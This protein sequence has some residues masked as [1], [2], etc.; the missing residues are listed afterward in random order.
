M[1]A[2][3]SE[4]GQHISIQKRSYFSQL[5]LI[6][7][8]IVVAFGCY[9]PSLT[10]G[11]MGDDYFAY[12][13]FFKA[14]HTNPLTLLQNFTGSWMSSELRELH[15]R[16]FMVI[17]HLFDC[18]A[19]HLNPFGY[20]LTNLIIH[21][22]CTALVFLITR[23]IFKSLHNS[24]NLLPPFIAALLFAVHPLHAEAVS[25]IAGRVDSF[26]TML[27]LS[28]FFL[29]L[30]FQ[31]TGSTYL[32]MISYACAL[33]AMMSKEIGAALPAVLTLYILC[34]NLAAQPILKTARKALKETSIYWILLFFYITVRT[35]ALKTLLGGYAGLTGILTENSWMHRIQDLK[36][37]EKIFLPI[38]WE[39]MQQ[40]SFYLVVLS[41]LSCLIVS[42]LLIRLWYCK[43]GLQ[44]ARVFCFATAWIA[45][46]FAIVCRVWVETEGLAGGR[47][48]YLLSVPYCILVALLLLPIGEQAKQH[49]ILNIVATSIMTLYCSVFFLITFEQNQFWTDAAD[50]SK[51]FRNAIISQIPKKGPF[52]VLNVPVTHEHMGLY[53]TFEVLRGLFSWPFCNPDLTDRVNSLQPYFYNS[54]LINKSALNM[55]LTDSTT[56]I[57]CWN[58]N[59]KMAS[60]YTSF[61]S[62]SPNYID[63]HL[64][65]IPHVERALVY[66]IKPLQPIKKQNIDC[67]E[68]SIACKPK[69]RKKPHVLALSW[70]DNTCAPQGLDKQVN[71]WQFADID[72]S[73]KQWVLDKDE[74]LATCLATLLHAE[75]DV[76]TYRFHLSEITSWNLFGKLDSL[77][78]MLTDPSA[79]YNIKS[80]KLLN[81]SNEIPRLSLQNSLWAR[82]QNGTYSAKSR[83]KY[84]FDYD[85]SKIKGAVKVIVEISPPDFYW[86]YFTTSY[87]Q[88]KLADKKL[89]TLMLN[90]LHGTFVIDPSIF[91][92]QADYQIHIAALDS[93][94]K[95]LDYV[96]DPLTI[97]IK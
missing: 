68:I 29:F 82:N 48:F 90:Q 37:Y 56:K 11:F 66:H 95:I 51:V 24:T 42:V 33:G 5:F 89:K 41:L 34:E 74:H 43:P 78:L 49:K 18:L 94:G 38:P 9:Y 96:S 55:V 71:M 45:I 16:P 59:K 7:I 86:E 77:R 2:S 44:F 14:L 13:Y 87:R 23:A 85:A 88:K 70:S 22:V 19:W 64:S 58:G 63:C 40:N 52:L 3:L 27:Y 80:V 93:S 46:Q 1:I 15:Y 54:N 25:W 53:P 67:L 39:M 35:C 79:N 62:N 73:Q 32:K 65:L 47:Q 84:V 57:I 26:C 10:S 69:Q 8:L 75:G 17:P 20:H 83:N 72:G 50:Y 21:A 81:L 31:Q 60:P 92:R 30:R 28:S 6:L 97:H 91:P 61:S 12:S 76:H 36:S 4:I